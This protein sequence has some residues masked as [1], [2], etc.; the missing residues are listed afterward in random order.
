[1]TTWTT[2]RTTKIKSKGFKYQKLDL[3]KCVLAYMCRVKFKGSS[4]LICPACN[5]SVHLRFGGE[6]NLA[7]HRT[8]KACKNKSQSRSK[9]SKPARNQ[10]LHA[11]FKPCVPLNPLTVTAPPMIHARIH[12]KGKVNETLDKTTHDPSIPS[13]SFESRETMEIDKEMGP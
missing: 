7:I 8:S 9:C 5:E 13:S 12:A 3:T 11:F 1:V 6:K 4:T 2:T 10:D